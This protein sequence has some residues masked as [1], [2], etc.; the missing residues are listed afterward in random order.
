MNETKST[1]S[2]KIITHLEKGA[3]FDIL[4]ARKGSFR[5]WDHQ[6]L[7]EMYVVVVKDKAKMK[8]KWDIF[9]LVETVPG[10]NESLELIQPTQQENPCTMAT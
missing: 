3:T 5:P 9:D 7:Q 10:P 4:K 2:E 8:D 1:A 6:M